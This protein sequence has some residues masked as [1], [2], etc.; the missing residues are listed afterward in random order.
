MCLLSAPS[1]EMRWGSLCVYC[2]PPLP[3]RGGV[4][5]CGLNLVCS[6]SGVCW[7]WGLDIGL[8]S[9]LQD[10]LELIIKR[11]V[12]QLT[13]ELDVSYNWV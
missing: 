9:H 2:L 13:A 6:P 7:R 10:V 4:P 1:A 12:F 8:F 11:L 3:K 5:V